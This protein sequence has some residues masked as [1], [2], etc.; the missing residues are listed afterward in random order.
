[1]IVLEFARSSQMSSQGSRLEG[2]DFVLRPDLAPPILVPGSIKEMRSPK[3][4]LTLN[5]WMAVYS[6][7]LY[8][9]L[10]YWLWFRL[11]STTKYKFIGGDGDRHIPCKRISEYFRSQGIGDR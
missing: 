2:G 3:L 1:M 9:S 4:S 6:L 11:A 7:E 10:G 5:G 8:Q